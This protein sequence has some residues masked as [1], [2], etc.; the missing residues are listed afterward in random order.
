MLRPPQGRFRAGLREIV[1]DGLDSVRRVVGAASARR[2]TRRIAAWSG[3]RQCV[4]LRDAGRARCQRRPAPPACLLL[5]DRSARALQPAECAVAGCQ[6]H[7]AGAAVGLGDGGRAD[8]GGLRPT[9]DGCVMVAF[10]STAAAAH[11]PVTPHAEAT[12]TYYGLPAVR[13]SVYHWR[14]ATYIFVGGLSG[15]VQILATV[16]D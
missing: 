12:V 6:A 8:G 3:R 13:P 5:A 14:V 16:A 4:S 11:P 7:R 2:E 1:P 9:R 15:G 10:E